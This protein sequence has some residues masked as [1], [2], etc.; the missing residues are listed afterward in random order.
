MTAFYRQNYN[1]RFATDFLT[2]NSV[3]KLTIYLTGSFFSIASITA[4]AAFFAMST[5]GTLNVVMNGTVSNESWY[6]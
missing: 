2:I 3:G 5:M 6:T 1:P 4:A